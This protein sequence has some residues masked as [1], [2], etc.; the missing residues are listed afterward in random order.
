MS[1]DTGKEILFKL[2]FI[3]CMLCGVYSVK[4][5]YSPN[6]SDSIHIVK[7]YL[8]EDLFQYFEISL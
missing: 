8:S 2:S 1:L 4:F 7:L 3:W 6:F 5:R